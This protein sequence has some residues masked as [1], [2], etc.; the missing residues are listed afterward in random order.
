R[1]LLGAESHDRL[2]QDV[3]L[4]DEAGHPFDEEAVMAGELSPVFFGSALTNFGVEPFL[5]EFLE[6][7]PEPTSRESS[8]GVVEPTDEKFT[9]FVFKIQANMDAKHRD[10]V[11]FVRVCSGRFEAGMQVKHVRSGKLVRLASPQQFLARE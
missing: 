10:R 11:A 3:A 5:R 9:G 1:D 6:L 7:A 2:V 4:L 8:A